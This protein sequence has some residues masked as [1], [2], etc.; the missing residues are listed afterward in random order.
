MLSLPW[1]GGSGDV[2][3]LGAFPG[4]MPAWKPAFCMWRLCGFFGC[5]VGKTCCIELWR[6]R[7]GRA[8]L[9][10]SRGLV[11]RG[12]K[13]REKKKKKPKSL[14][15]V[16]SGLG[17]LVSCVSLQ[18]RAGPVLHSSWDLMTPY[19]GLHRGVSHG[20]LRGILGVKTIALMSV[21]VAHMHIHIYI[22]TFVWSHSCLKN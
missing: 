10:F 11:L 20:L 4:V 13:V 9:A 3:S 12:E 16:K 18:A 5:A 15:A 1:R 14:S 8:L 17:R 22:Y 7:R 21:K 2:S 19:R 6:Y